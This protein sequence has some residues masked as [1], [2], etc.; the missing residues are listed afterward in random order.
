MPRL[1]DP[2]RRLRVDALG[3][4]LRGRDGRLTLLVRLTEFFPLVLTLPLTFG[5]RKRRVPAAAPLLRLHD[6]LLNTAVSSLLAYK[7]SVIRRTRRATR[8]SKIAPFEAVLDANIPV[9]PLLRNVATR[10]RAPRPTP[11]PKRKLAEPTSH[12]PSVLPIVGLQTRPRHKR[13]LVF[14]DML[15]RRPLR[16]GQPSRQRHTDVAL[17]RP[18]GAGAWAHRRLRPNSHAV[19]STAAYRQLARTSRRALG[20]LLLPPRLAL[21]C[22][23]SPLPPVA[24]WPTNVASF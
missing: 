1:P 2:T 3:G 22:R 20:D 17:V 11:P 10:R 7:L 5:R 21:P 6:R 19:A 4:T 18:V 23:P 14:P 24:T 9:A 8:P 16:L 12:N 13:P 15:P